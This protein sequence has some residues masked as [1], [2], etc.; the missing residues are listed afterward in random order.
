MKIKDIKEYLKSI[1][2]LLSEY[3]Q[4]DLSLKLHPRKIYLQHY[5]K[6]VQFLGVVVKPYRIYIGNQTKGIFYKKIQL[7]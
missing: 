5:I 3:L 6:G 1:I 2:P 7:K 4:S